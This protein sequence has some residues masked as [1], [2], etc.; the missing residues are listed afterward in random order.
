VDAVRARQ[1]LIIENAGL[2]HQVNVLRCRSKSP[3]LNVMDRLKLLIGARLL[4]PWRRAI[5]IV[6]PETVCA[7][8][9]QASAYSGGGDLAL[10]RRRHCHPR[11]SSSSATLRCEGDSGAQQA[12]G[13]EVHARCSQSR[14]RPELGGLPG[15]PAGCDS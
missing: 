2:R 12:D 14:R 13:P 6:Q 9:V 7:G 5:A 3:N 11:R 8:I 15:H 1:E 10:G 4:P